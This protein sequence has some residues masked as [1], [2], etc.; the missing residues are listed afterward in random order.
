[1]S[2]VQLLTHSAPREDKD[3]MANNTL[4]SQ[5]LCLEVRFDATEQYSYL[6]EAGGMCLKI[7]ACEW[8]AFFFFCGVSDLS[9]QI[10][11]QA[12]WEGIYSRKGKDEHFPGMIWLPSRQNHSHLHAGTVIMAC[13]NAYF[14]PKN[15]RLKTMWGFSWH[16]W[17]WIPSWITKIFSLTFLLM[18]LTSCYNTTISGLR[19]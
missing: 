4:H 14:T 8:D 16:E 15:F 13:S 3:V 6:Q 18:T 19:T 10:L 11:S 5:A 7:A 12:S 2:L 17:W 9:L 1:M